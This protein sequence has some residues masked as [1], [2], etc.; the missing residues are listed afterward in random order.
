MQSYQFLYYTIVGLI[1]AVSR[2]SVKIGTLEI[3]RYTVHKFI[4]MLIHVQQEKG[5]EFE[6]ISHTCVKCF[7]EGWGKVWG[8]EKRYEKVR[9]RITVCEK[10]VRVWKRSCYGG[11]SE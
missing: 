9:V 11:D 2:L 3:P 10:S 1:F 8:R 4:Y 7:T 6:R 5:C